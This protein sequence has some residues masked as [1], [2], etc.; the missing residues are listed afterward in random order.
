MTDCE[1][2]YPDINAIPNSDKFDCGTTWVLCGWGYYENDPTKPDLVGDYLACGGG[3]CSGIS[4]Y[5]DTHTVS[6]ERF[7]DFVALED[8]DDSGGDR[9]NNSAGNKG[10]TTVGKKG[11][12]CD[13]GGLAGAYSTRAWYSATGYAPITTQYLNCS[14]KDYGIEYGYC[15]TGSHYNT[16]DRYEDFEP[17][18]PPTVM[19]NLN[20]TIID[21]YLAGLDS[22]LGV[23]NNGIMDN[24]SN[25]TSIHYGGL[26]GNCTINGTI[27]NDVVYSIAKL[28]FIEENG[29]LGFDNHFDPSYCDEAEPVVTVP[30]LIILGMYGLLFAIAIIATMGVVIVVG[31]GVS[32]LTAPIFIAAG[33]KAK[34]FINKRIRERSKRRRY[35][36]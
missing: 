12:V 3:G 20:H 19:C 30:I 14:Y 16:S 13:P 33:E 5:M 26:C 22:G 35:G 24:A 10:I 18:T 31:F 11:I 9:D 8:C 17:S 4:G 21:D 1:N 29:V 27:T 36:A 34:N 15:D 2:E 28:V 32:A 7:I 23:C 25:E 6:D